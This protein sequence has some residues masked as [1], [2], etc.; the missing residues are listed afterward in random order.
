M[1]KDSIVVQV[2]SWHGEGAPA[3]TAIRALLPTHMRAVYT[4][5]TDAPTAWGIAAQAT[6]PH[7]N[8]I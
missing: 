2:A 7:P 1:I 4:K 5:P 8:E 6:P 3:S